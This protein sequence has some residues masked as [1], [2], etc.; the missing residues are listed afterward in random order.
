MHETSA[1]A[2]REASGS[3]NAVDHAQAL[4]GCAF[5]CVR[6]ALGI[7]EKSKFAQCCFKTG[8]ML[9]YT[10]CDGGKGTPIRAP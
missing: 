5:D 4:G 6:V 7:I 3:R 2:T 9:I 8:N 1:F 10:S